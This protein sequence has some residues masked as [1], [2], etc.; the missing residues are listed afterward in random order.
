[1]SFF[2]MTSRL[3]CQVLTDLPCLSFTGIFGLGKVGFFKG[4]LAFEVFSWC[5][6]L[7]L[8]FYIGIWPLK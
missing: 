5:V 1:M 6:S 2:P 3:E 7:I 4:I 8:P